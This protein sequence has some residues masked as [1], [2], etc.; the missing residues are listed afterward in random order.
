ISLMIIDCRKFTNTDGDVARTV[1]VG[2]GP[3][4]LMLAFYLARRGCPVLV[5]EGGGPLASAN[6]ANDLEAEVTATPLPGIVAGGTR[7]M[8]GGLNR[9]GGQLASL[10]PREFQPQDGNSTGWPIPQSEI[11]SRFASVAELLGEPVVNLPPRGHH[12]ETERSA[13]AAAGLDII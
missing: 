3:V 1:I 7:Q 5:I 6:V 8:G 10:E 13:L 11:S 9:G 12:F 2:S 4:G